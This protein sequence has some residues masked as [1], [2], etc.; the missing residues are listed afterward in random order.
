MSNPVTEFL[1]LEKQGDWRQFGGQ[2]AL[3]AGTVAAG[4]LMNEAVSAVRGAVRKSHNF[5]A[6]MAHNPGLEKEDRARVQGLFNT[7]HNVSPD[8]AADPVVANSWVKRMMY[9]DEYVDPR[10]LSDLATA[11]NRMRPDT[12][13]L[14][15]VNIAQEGVRAGI[16]SGAAPWTPS[17]GGGGAPPVTVYGPTFKVY[18]ARVK[19]GGSPHG[20]VGPQMRNQRP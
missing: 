13:G 17:R 5:K 8:L 20:G 19:G 15:F 7:L 12:K 6:M 9:Q 3:A 2:M 18:G 4:A 1:E 11:Q 16:S 10:M 14:D